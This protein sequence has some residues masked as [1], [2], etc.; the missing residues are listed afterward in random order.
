MSCLLK[1]QSFTNSLCYRQKAIRIIKR[2]SK[3][4]ITKT[5]RNA[6]RQE[7]VRKNCGILSKQHRSYS[8]KS[9]NGKKQ[10]ESIEFFDEKFDPQQI[11]AKMIYSDKRVPGKDSIKELTTLQKISNY[12]LA[13][14]LMGFV[15]GVF[16]Y[17]MNVVG[18]TE[19]AIEDLVKEASFAKERTAAEEEVEELLE[20]EGNV[21]VE[22]A[23]A[24]DAATAEKMEKE[25]LG[26]K[27]DTEDNTKN[28]NRPIW[29]KIL[30]F[31]K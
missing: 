29:K 2:S 18:R 10:A 16:F 17:S 23:I 26:N 31:W 9:K 11:A 1:Y 24:A 13:T 19:D 6:V 27:V 22:V 12:V 21:D 8:T 28:G 4:F 30:L 3:N 14:V 25:L 5:S 7:L 20:L 15:S